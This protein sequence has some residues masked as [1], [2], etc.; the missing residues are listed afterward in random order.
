MK[1]KFER[2]D[3]LLYRRQYQTAGGKSR[4]LYYGIF[5]DLKGNGVAFPLGNTSNGQE[6]NSAN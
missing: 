6:T 3:P 5:V 2:I 4:V 1:E